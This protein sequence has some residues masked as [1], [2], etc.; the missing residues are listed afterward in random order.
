MKWIF[1]F[2][3]NKKLQR[4][5]QN[6]VDEGCWLV[7]GTTFFVIKHLQMLYLPLSPSNNFFLR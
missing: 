2:S 3:K 5:L 4:L 6:F 1:S 7:L